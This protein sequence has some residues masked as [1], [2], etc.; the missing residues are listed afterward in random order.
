MTRQKQQGQVIRAG[1]LRRRKAAELAAQKAHPSAHLLASLS[2][3]WAAMSDAIL[4]ASTGA[5]Q[6]HVVVLPL[7]V[8]A[9][10]GL[11][12]GAGLGDTTTGMALMVSPGRLML[13]AGAGLGEPG[14]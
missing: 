13:V 8:G 10:L 11:A 14:D 2:H 3:S 4:S 6:L 5:G 9:G 12:A 1:V 7:S